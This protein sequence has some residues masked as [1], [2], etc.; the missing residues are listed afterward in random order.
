M[1]YSQLGGGI[2]GPEGTTGRTITFALA[3][4]VMV[5]GFLA[6]NVAPRSAVAPAIQPVVPPTIPSTEPVTGRT[7]T[8]DRAGQLSNDQR[9]HLAHADQQLV[10]AAEQLNG[11]R[12]V[13]ASL[14]QVLN[15]NYLQHEKRRAESAWAACDAA[16]RALEDAREHLGI[17]TRKE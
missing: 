12:L 8:K 10:T 7:D 5:L 17:I 9:L 6:W 14:T 2:G 15:R 11:A 4:L 13:L 1:S 3:G 16:Q